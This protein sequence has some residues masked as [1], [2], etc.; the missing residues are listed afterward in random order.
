MRPELERALDGAYA[1][2]NWWLEGLWIGLPPRARAS[3]FAERAELTV[4]LAGD[5]A[6]VGG[7]DAASVTVDTRD[8]EATGA[9]AQLGAQ[10]A[11]AR[12]HATAAARR[13]A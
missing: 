7:R 1:A 12:R 13:R 6:T 5:T 4:H 8:A 2:L 11:R 10:R 9:L 3:L